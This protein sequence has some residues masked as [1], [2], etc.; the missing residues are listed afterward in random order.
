[1]SA[2]N[3]ALFILYPAILPFLLLA[4]AAIFV[5]AWP[6]CLFVDLNPTTAKGTNA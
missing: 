5:I 3:L 1:M 4:I 2:K 6:A